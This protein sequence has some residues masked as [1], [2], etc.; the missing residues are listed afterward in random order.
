MYNLLNP[1]ISPKI[2]KVHHVDLKRWGLQLSP[3]N[4]TK[5]ETIFYKTLREWIDDFYQFEDKFFLAYF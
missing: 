5:S 3:L 2:L 4:L 1:D